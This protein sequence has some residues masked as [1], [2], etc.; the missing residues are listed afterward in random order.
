MQAALERAKARGMTIDLTAGPSWP[1][2]V[3]S[4]TPDSPGAIKEL[5]YGSRDVTGG[6]SFSGPAPAPVVA[7]NAGRHAEEAPLRPGREGHD[8]R[9]PAG[10]APTRSTGFA[11]EAPP[12]GD[13]NVNLTAPDSGNWVLISYWERG[14][15]QKPRAARTRRP[16]RT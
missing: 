8:R 2:A 10:D 12:D 7:P 3:P 11:A 1:S 5:A 15:G 9:Q 6:Q 14:S 4:V 13:G 16:T